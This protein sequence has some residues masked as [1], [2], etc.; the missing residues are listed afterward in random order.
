[1]GSDETNRMKDEL[2]EEIL[3]D[4]DPSDAAGHGFL[5][6]PP[7]EE[8]A[9]AHDGEDTPDSGEAGHEHMDHTRMH[10]EMF[11]RDASGRV[12]RVDPEKIPRDTSGYDDQGNDPGTGPPT[13]E[14]AEGKHEHPEHTHGGSDPEEAS[15]KPRRR[16]N[17]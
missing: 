9:T 15:P 17:R 12:V 4:L 10:F 5:S 2:L 14:R 1:M 8:P 16:S 7:P 13:P 3:A 11:R 6:V